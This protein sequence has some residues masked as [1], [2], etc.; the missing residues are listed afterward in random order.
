M[1]WCITAEADELAHQK[2]EELR[3]EIDRDTMVNF[4]KQNAAIDAFKDNQVDDGD[5]YAGLGQEFYENYALGFT[6]SQLV[7]SPETIAERMRALDQDA[8]VE[9]LLMCFVDP[10]K[11]L[12][13]IE[14][15]IM[16][17]LKKMGLRF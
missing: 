16:P 15:S 8:G 7:G 10:Q 13:A 12:H 17:I 11:G 14:D 2:F 9:S 5:P 4:S 1:C 6:S 3:V